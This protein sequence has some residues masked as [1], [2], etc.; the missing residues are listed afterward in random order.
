M[1]NVIASLISY[2]NY[3]GNKPQLMSSL[4]LE[5]LTLNMGYGS[6]KKTKPLLLSGF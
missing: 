5:M 4:S 1:S 3:L 6:N 2:I